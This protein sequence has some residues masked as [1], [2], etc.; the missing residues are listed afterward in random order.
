MRPVE[1][2]AIND[3]SWITIREFQDRVSRVIDRFFGILDLPFMKARILDFLKSNKIWNWK[4][5][6]EPLGC[7][8]EQTELGFWAKNKYKA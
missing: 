4:Y 1:V 7:Q 8:K 5:A 2:W 3:A 6:R